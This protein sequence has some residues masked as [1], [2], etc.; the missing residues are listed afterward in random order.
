M[1]TLEI[2]DFIEVSSN[3]RNYDLQ[4]KIYFKRLLPVA[5]EIKLTHCLL[6]ILR[7]TYI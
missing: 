2:K 7:T 5:N 1:K 6:M 3:V 4:I